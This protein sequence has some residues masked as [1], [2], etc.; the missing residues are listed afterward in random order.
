MKSPKR[1]IALALVVASGMLP[2][3][4]VGGRQA[5]Q[6]SDPIY[7]Q[8]LST[9]AVLYMLR[10]GGG[11]SIVL[12]R[13]EGVV[14]IDSK[15]PGRTQE[16]VDAVSLVTERPITTIINTHAHIDHTGGNLEVPGVVDI[17]AHERTK[18][19]MQK[20]EAFTGRGAKYQPNKTVTEKMS[21]FE[22]RDR[23]D[24][25][26]F[27]AGHTNGV[28]VVVLAGHDIGYLG[29]LFPAKARAPL[30]DRAHGGSGVAF[31]ETLDR[32]IREIKGVSRVVA[33]HDPGPP[34]DAPRN[35]FGHIQSWD[36]LQQYAEFNR[37]FL[38]A[39]RSAIAQGK[40]AA[41]AAASLTLP[42]KY[43][44]YDMT[45]AKANVEI[46]FNELSPSNRIAR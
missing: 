29:D 6:Q 26:Y 3:A 34:P 7:V 2:A 38:A 13:D 15:P 12:V 5:P 45:H 9:G 31:P 42:A 36:D 19:A 35:A 37:D 20:M 40:S 30:I 11:S 28:L 33:G 41:Q 14:L 39:V 23:F 21:V 44:G 16:L 43:A 18:A 8:L 4:A 10:G 25:Y 27:G 17:I 22:G 24:L 32:V 46:I 1:L